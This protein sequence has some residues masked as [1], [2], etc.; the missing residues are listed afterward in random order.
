V[1][2]ARFS[3]HKFIMWKDKRPVLLISTHTR[4]IQA[5]YENPVVTVPRRQGATRVNIQTSPV[6]LEYTTDMRGVDVADQLRASYSAQVR[7]H[8]W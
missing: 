4:P 5:P 2:N 6:L 7:S 1:E 3:Y 8:K